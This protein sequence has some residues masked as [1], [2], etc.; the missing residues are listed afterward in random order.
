MKSRRLAIHGTTAQVAALEPW[1]WGMAVV[2]S[3]PWL[4]YF[5][6]VRITEIAS[7]FR[8]DAASQTEKTK[9]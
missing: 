5:L 9:P 6:L 2:G 7:A 1:A 8:G 4:W 3:L